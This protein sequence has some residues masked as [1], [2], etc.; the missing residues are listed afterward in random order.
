MY[1]KLIFGQLSLGLNLVQN[2]HKGEI[3]V[4]R[5][6]PEYKFPFVIRLSILSDF[7]DS[8]IQQGNWCYQRRFFLINSYQKRSKNFTIKNSKNINSRSAKKGR[9]SVIFLRFWTFS[10]NSIFQ[11][12]FFSIIFWKDNELIWYQ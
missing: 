10:Q 2:S 11:R 12:L 5:K 8:K 1:F 3:G 4:L 9:K 7:S 6:R